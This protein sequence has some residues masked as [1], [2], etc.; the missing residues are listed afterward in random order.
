MEGKEQKQF[1]LMVNGQKVEVSEEVY[2]AYV[3]PVR[4]QQRADRRNWRCIVTGEKY[5]L[6]RCKAD[7]NECPYAQQ[8]N[9]PTGNETSLDVLYESGFDASAAFDM[10]ADLIDCEER[11]EQAARVQK[12]IGQLNER[13]Q[14]IVQAIYFDGKSKTEVA[15]ELGLKKSALSQALFRIMQFLKKFLQEK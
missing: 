3:R 5:G 9:A 6:V 12:A 11:V 15:Q 7:C 10:E 8:G 13:Q 4:A 1:Y 2:R 14:Y